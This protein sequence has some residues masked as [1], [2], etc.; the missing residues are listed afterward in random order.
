MT[1]PEER[2]IDSAAQQMIN[3]AQDDGIDLAWDRYEEM[4][5]QCGFGQLGICCRI[6]HMGPCRVDPFGGGPQE[7]VCGADANAM[8]RATPTPATKSA[9]P[10]S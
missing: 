1:A 10:R 2:S 9:T 4:Q 5:P 8:R 7:G 6:C 3:R